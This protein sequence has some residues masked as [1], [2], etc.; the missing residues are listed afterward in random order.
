M[1]PLQVEHQGFVQVYIQVVQLSDFWDSGAGSRC[2]ARLFTVLPCVDHCTTRRKGAHGR[3]PGWK[4][5]LFLPVGMTSG[6]FALA[7]V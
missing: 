2:A 3:V 1:I 7:L 6:H 4:T 5:G